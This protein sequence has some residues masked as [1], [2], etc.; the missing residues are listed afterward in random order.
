MPPTNADPPL[1]DPEH[2]AFIEGGVSISVASSS[3][4]NVPAVSRAVG[5]RV[6]PDRRRITV[7]LAASRSAA[8]LEAIAASRRIAAAF[9]Q[10]STHRTIQLKGVDAG[11]TAV[12]P[13]DH[14]R[15]QRYLRALGADLKLA[16]YDEEVARLLLGHEP[17]DVVA[18][19]FTPSA[20]FNQTPGPGAGGPLARS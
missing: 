5:C 16:S 7:F 15:A 4:A 13:A 20:A 9:S 8:L 2:A 1:L 19:A 12:E 14:E 3:E 17:A 11:Q 6:S 10:P 18:V